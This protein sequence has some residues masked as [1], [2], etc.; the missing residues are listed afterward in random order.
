MDMREWDEALCEL[1]LDHAQL[2]ARLG[3]D[4]DDHRRAASVRELLLAG[5][6][7]PTAT[8]HLTLEETD[9]T[10]EELTAAG[11]ST[12]DIA[13]YER[14]TDALLGDSYQP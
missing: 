2:V 7:D 1:Q 4:G 13:A 3:V 9:L 10:P 8:C 14:V 6:T 11:A 5:R 12:C